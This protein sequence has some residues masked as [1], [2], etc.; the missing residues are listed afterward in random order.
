MPDDL[1]N[2]KTKLVKNKS[3]YDKLLEEIHGNCHYC[4]KWTATLCGHCYQYPTRPK[5]EVIEELRW[6][7]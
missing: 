4:Q 1:D 6:V 2:L 7:D 3:I 5:W